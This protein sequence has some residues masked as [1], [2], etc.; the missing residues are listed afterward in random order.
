[1]EGTVAD[2]TGANVPGA[3][4]TATNLGTNALRETVT[5]TEGAFSITPLPA[6]PYQ[7][8]VSMPGFKEQTTKLTLNVNQVARLEFKLE[9]GGVTETVE[10]TGVASLI[11]RSTSFIG[12]VV[13]S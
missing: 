7:I 13:D 5:D 11:D 2:T 6:G 10:V 3:S 12:T 4:V 9:L 8:K 1:V